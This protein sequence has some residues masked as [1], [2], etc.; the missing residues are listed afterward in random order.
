MLI[1]LFLVR[2]TS[3]PRTKNIE[4]A[5]SL[6]ARLTEMCQGEIAKKRLARRAIPFLLVRA[7]VNKNKGKMV[8]A[9]KSAEGNLTANSLSPSIAIEGIVK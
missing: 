5:T 7:K 6:V 2:K 4:I 9:P 8:S 1:N 3:P